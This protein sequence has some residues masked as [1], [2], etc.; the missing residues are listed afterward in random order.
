LNVDNLKAVRKEQIPNLSRAL[1]ATDICFLIESLSDKNDKLRYTSFLLL[2]ANSKEYPGV[3]AY[4]S[5]LEKK[6]DNDNSYQRSLG[7]MLIAENVKWDIE[8]RFS[9]IISKYMK[10]CHDEKF[11]TA[12]QTIQ[13]LGTIVKTTAKFDKEIKQGISSLQ[14]SEYKENQQKLL[15]KDVTNV[16]NVIEKRR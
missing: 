4:W 8:G 6:L 15:K 10:C 14:F 1:T 7:I 2:Q 9:K 13:G 11:I 16:L 5:V 12:R 3:Y